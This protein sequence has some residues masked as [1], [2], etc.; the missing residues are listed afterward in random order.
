MR[1]KDTQKEM[2]SISNGHKGSFISSLIE[3]TK[4][5]PGNFN[6]EYMKIKSELTLLKQF[7]EQFCQHNRL[8]NNLFIP[9]YTY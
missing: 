2:F 6:E 4:P 8:M 7:L 3:K 9:Y 1:T 5:L